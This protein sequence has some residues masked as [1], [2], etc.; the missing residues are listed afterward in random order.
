MGDK[1][2]F[3]EGHHYCHFHRYAH[4]VSAADSLR[5]DEVL[6]VSISLRKEAPATI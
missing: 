3:R 2:K 1:V 6:V 4:P 5:N